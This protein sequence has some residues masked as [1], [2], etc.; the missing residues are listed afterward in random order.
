MYKEKYLKYKTKYL[1]LKNQSGGRLHQKGG[2]YYFQGLHQKARGPHPEY[3]KLGASRAYVPN[4]RVP[5][6]F[7]WP[8]YKPTSFTHPIVTSEPK[9]VWADDEKITPEITDRIKTKGT[10]CTDN[11]GNKLIIQFDEKTQRPL[12]C[13]GRTGM[14]GRGL[15]GKWGPNFA[16]DPIVTRFKPKEEGEPLGE[17]H[18]ELQIALIQR[19]D[20]LEWAL[21]GGMVDPEDQN[22]SIT[23]KREFAEEALDI[24]DPDL[25][26]KMH[27]KINDLFASGGITIYEGYVDDP[28]NTDNAWMETTA[29][30]FH[31]SKEVGDK[32]ELHAGDDAGKARWFTISEIKKPEFYEKL[33]ASHPPMIEEAIR[34]S[35]CLNSNKSKSPISPK[36][37]TSQKPKR[38]QHLQRLPNRQIID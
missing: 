15:L 36:S 2:V 18:D 26:K 38:L 11:I 33:Y 1:A 17:L 23:A 16:A 9:P 22:T 35:L 37:P 5:W 10:L 13:L 4:T 7:Y 29:H 28:R 14:S 12:N 30:L 21:P 31:L 20:T 6:S 8:E 3:L 27:K 25:K 32:M 34:V 19:R 24:P